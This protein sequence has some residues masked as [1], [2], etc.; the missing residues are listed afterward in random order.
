[1]RPFNRPD[2]RCCWNHCRLTALL[3]FG[4][5]RLRQPFLREQQQLCL[6]RWAGGLRRFRPAFFIICAKFLTP[7]HARTVSPKIQPELCNISTALIQIKKRRYAVCAKTSLRLVAVVHN[8][9]NV[10]CQPVQM[11]VQ[12]VEHLALRLIRSQ[13]ADQRSLRRVLTELFERGL[14]ILY[15]RGSGSFSIF[16][17]WAGDGNRLGPCA[18]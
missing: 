12:P 7:I 6:G 1:M 18:A 15:G 17:R 8:S 16:S 9:L 11:L 13:V 14:V 5:F 2:F 3:I 10:V 4:G